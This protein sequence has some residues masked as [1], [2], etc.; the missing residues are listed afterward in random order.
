MSLWKNISRILALTLGLGPAVFAASLTPG[1]ILISSEEVLYEYTT[2]GVFVQSLPIPDYTGEIPNLSTA[3]DIAVKVGSDLVHV[4]N[5]TFEPFL[6]TVNMVTSSWSHDTY[7]G[8]SIINNSTY[9]GIAVTGDYVFVTDMSASLGTEMGIIRFDLGGSTVRFADTTAPIDLNMGLDGLLY[10][11]DGQYVR[12]YNPATLAL[13]NTINLHSTIAFNDYRSVAANSA[14]EMFVVDWD[15]DIHKTDSSGNGVLSVSLTSTAQS[16]FL[17]DVDVAAT[18]TVIVG[19]NSGGVT[20]TDES[21][22]SPTGFAVGTS[23]IFVGIQTNAPVPVE[24]STFA[25]D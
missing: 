25:L 7:G 14:G 13:L 23:A 2:A 8:W 10:A 21:F 6:S 22:A 5:G 1:N 11:L 17:M 15:G 24:L 19:D 20:I 4:F 18:G 12:I 3:R 9:G 16:K